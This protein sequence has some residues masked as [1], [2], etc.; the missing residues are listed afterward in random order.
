MKSSK[1]FSS[2]IMVL[3]LMQQVAGQFRKKMNVARAPN[4]LICH[5]R[6]CFLETFCSLWLQLGKN[7]WHSIELQMKEYFFPRLH[8]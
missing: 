5:C 2:L 6:R 4:I 3:L 1:F 7:T 8:P